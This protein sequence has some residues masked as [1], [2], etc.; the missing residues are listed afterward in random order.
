M[1]L[2]VQTAHFP[3]VDPDTLYHAY[4]SSQDHAAMTAGGLHA[5][6]VRAGVGEVAHGQV[7][8]TLRAFGAP[9]PDGEM[10]YSLQARIVALVPGRVIVMSW[11]NRLWDEPLDPADGTDLESTV[12]LTFREN[13]AGAEI[14]LVQA[15]VP[16]YT[17]AIP[18]LSEV[19]PASTI[20]NTHWHLLYWEPM[21]QYFA[22]RTPEGGALLR[23]Q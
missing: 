12:V 2:I 15:N 20:I 6:F 16:D 4:L 1:S 21:R 11:R 23:E 8:D 3:G 13:V 19:G 9:G 22:R 17:A 18:E 5:A 7:G 14:Q 10:R